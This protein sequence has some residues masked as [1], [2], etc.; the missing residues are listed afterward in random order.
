MKIVNDLKLLGDSSPITIYKIIQIVMEERDRAWEEM[1]RESID[2]WQHT[3][4][5]WL[6]LEVLEPYG[7]SI[8]IFL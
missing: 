1:N 4:I 2:N 5:G 6:A 7:L 8:L 3:P